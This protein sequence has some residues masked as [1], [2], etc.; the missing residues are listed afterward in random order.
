MRIGSGAPFFQMMVSFTIGSIY[1]R[2]ATGAAQAS[3]GAIT[4]ALRNPGFA[5]G[6]ARRACARTAHR[7]QLAA[8]PCYRAGIELELAK[9]LIKRKDRHEARRHIE[10]TIAFLQPT[11]DC[12]AMREARALLEQLD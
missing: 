11:V 5:F 8:Q 1:A 2:I 4:A 10:K 9:L 3:G 6:K 7:A 12:V